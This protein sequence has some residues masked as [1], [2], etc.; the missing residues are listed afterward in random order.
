[1]MISSPVG[2]L[3]S[4]GSWWLSA[5][6]AVSSVDHDDDCIAYLRLFIRI[7]IGDEL[8]WCF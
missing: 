2:D 4:C 5:Y 3:I 7:M 8:I 1:M 6:M